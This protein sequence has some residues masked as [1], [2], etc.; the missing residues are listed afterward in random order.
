MAR[1]YSSKRARREAQAQ[2]RASNHFKA[3]YELLRAA[4]KGISSVYELKA[5]LA[6]HTSD[7][8]LRE[9]LYK[10]MFPM[11]SEEARRGFAG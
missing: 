9:H 6:R 4:M 3:D 8:V 1:I 11:L 5:Y 10:L 7:P 2:Q